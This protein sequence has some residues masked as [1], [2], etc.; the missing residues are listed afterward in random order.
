MSQRNLQET[1]KI[2]QQSNS[3]T[4]RFIGSVVFAIFFQRKLYGI[5]PSWQNCQERLTKS[6]RS[7]HEITV[8]LLKSNW[9]PGQ[10]WVVVMV[11]LIT[12]FWISRWDVGWIEYIF[13]QHS[14][15]CKIQ[16]NS[17]NYVNS[18]Y[19]TVIGQ[20]IWFN[21]STFMTCDLIMVPIL[22]YS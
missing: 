11:L 19:I 2:K 1:Q 4:T 6:T 14:V 17:K 21:V 20:H 7:C 22:K 18:D 9:N 8:A 3:R 12:R 13:E 5:L 10:H 16:Y 15:T